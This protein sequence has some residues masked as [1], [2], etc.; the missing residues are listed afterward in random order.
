MIN[1]NHDALYILFLYLLINLIYR[2][3]IKLNIKAFITLL[4][5]NPLRL[6]EQFRTQN[7]AVRFSIEIVVVLPMSI[8]WTPMMAHAGSIMGFASM[9]QNV[10]ILGCLVPV[11][12]TTITLGKS[13]YRLY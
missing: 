1:N 5:V 6:N 9:L 10:R 12:F 11:D 4:T 13:R 8:S 3:L 2:Y 7:R